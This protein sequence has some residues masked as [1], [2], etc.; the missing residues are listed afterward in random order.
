MLTLTACSVHSDNT[1]PPS[2]SVQGSRAY[3]ISVDLNR[4]PFVISSSIRAR[5]FAG[6]EEYPMN[7]S[8]EG[9]WDFDLPILCRPTPFNYNFKID[10]KYLALIIP[11]PDD[12]RDPATGFYSASFTPLPPVRIMPPELLMYGEA[13]GGTLTNTVEILNQSLGTLT[14][15]NISIVTPSGFCGFGE[16]SGS[17]F[18]ISS[19]PPSLPLQLKCGDEAA[20]NISFGSTTQSSGLLTINTDMGTYN[21]PLS[22]KLFL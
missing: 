12:R 2:A 20:I 21:V 14:I 16:C 15:T 19:A 3:P 10:W 5:V 13:S 9:T 1:T 4:D 22:G 18:S 7:G 6:E 11:A 8:G 17:N